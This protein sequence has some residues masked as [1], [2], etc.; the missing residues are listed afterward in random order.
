ME[1]KICSIDE[2]TLHYSS[3]IRLKKVRDILKHQDKL[4]Y[5]NMLIFFNCKKWIPIVFLNKKKRRNFSNL[6]FWRKIVDIILKVIIKDVSPCREFWTLSK[7]RKILWISLVFNF[8][9]NFS[10]R[11]RKSICVLNTDKYFLGIYSGK[12]KLIPCLL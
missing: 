12:R 11:I 6:Q 2:K 1:R 3:Q 9:G 8:Y 4:N 5:Q 10:L 7:Y